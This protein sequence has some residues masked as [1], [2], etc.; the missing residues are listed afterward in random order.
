MI[1]SVNLL[2]NQTKEGGARSPTARVIN[3][4]CKDSR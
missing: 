3:V 1:K 2:L 4:L